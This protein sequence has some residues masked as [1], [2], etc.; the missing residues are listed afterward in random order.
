MLGLNLLA[1]A[2]IDDRQVRRPAK[3]F[4]QHAFAVGCKMGDDDKGETAVGRN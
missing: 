2:G 4:G 1:V 3:N